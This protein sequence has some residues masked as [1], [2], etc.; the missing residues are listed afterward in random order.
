M[1][2]P[3]AEEIK[4]GAQPKIMTPAEVEKEMQKEKK[5]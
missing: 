4:K 3:S 1:K 2:V 5:Q